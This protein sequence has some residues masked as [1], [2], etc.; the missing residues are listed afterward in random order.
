[1][2]L[3]VVSKGAVYDGE[4]THDCCSAKDIY[5]LIW[6]QVDDDAESEPHIGQC[7][8]GEDEREDIIL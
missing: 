6:K 3:L 8:P 7:K 1:M 4:S 2:G 5:V